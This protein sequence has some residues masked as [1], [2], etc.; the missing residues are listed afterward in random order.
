MDDA[1]KSIKAFLYDRAVSPFFG[2]FVTAWSMWNYRFFL[3][4]LSERLDYP[5][6]ASL[7]RQSF[8]QLTLPFLP[9]LS[10]NSYNT[11]VNGILIPFLLSVGYFY[12]YP[13]IANPI[14]EL[15]LENDKYLKE[16]KQKKQKL[17][18]LSQEES[19]HLYSQLSKVENELASRSEQYQRKISA[20]LIE[21][22]Q[23]NSKIDELQEKIN[24]LTLNPEPTS[25]I[26]PEEAG[27]RESIE[28][29]DSHPT[30]TLIAEETAE[31][32]RDIS[33]LTEKFLSFFIHNMS[34]LPY[35]ISTLTGI[36][37]QRTL[38]MADELL[39]DGVISR[40]STGKLSLTPKGRDILLEKK[41]I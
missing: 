23:R 7:I 10:S 35:D 37:I 30:P 9:T 12:I 41:M 36:N 1:L 17:K 29:K 5:E 3:I 8:E 28:D 2:A 15:S 38:L 31:E 25:N 22:D 26:L 19:D 6:K 40:S 39:R 34:G 20:L 27:A 33:T 4:I 16:I 13:R 24:E 14:Y 32:S 21:N 18:L 11:G